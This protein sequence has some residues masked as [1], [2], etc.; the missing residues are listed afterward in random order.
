MLIKQNSRKLNSFFSSVQSLD[1]CEKLKIF[2]LNPILGLIVKKLKKRLTEKENDAWYAMIKFEIDFYDLL[3][4][5]RIKYNLEPLIDIFTARTNNFTN[6][7]ENKKTNVLNHTFE[8]IDS[9]CKETTRLFKECQQIKAQSRKISVAR[10]D[11]GFINLFKNFGTEAILLDETR[12]LVFINKTTYISIHKYVYT[13]QLCTIFNLKEFKI[14]VSYDVQQGY[15][16]V[17]FPEKNSKGKYLFIN[18]FHLLASDQACQTNGL[19]KYL[20]DEIVQLA[21]DDKCNQI[22]GELSHADMKSMAHKARFIDFVKFWESAGYTFG[23]H[24]VVKFLDFKN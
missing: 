7:C 12:E 24:E 14:N 23:N 16:V 6:E 2:L 9:L 18:D 5:F 13:S 21:T 15:D 4:D 17:V 3:D 19:G 22:R 1:L 8:Q 10:N 11:T 20:A